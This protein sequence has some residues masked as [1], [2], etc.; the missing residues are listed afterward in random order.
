[1]KFKIYSNLAGGHISVEAVAL[2][3]DEF[4]SIKDKENTPEFVF[5]KDNDTL[6][7]NEFTCIGGYHG[8]CECTTHDR[9][10]WRKYDLQADCWANKV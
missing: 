10:V 9:K 7:Y 8:T 2:T 6:V 5:I 1:M 4:R 3:S